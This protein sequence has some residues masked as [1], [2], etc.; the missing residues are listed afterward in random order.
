M[1]LLNLDRINEYAPYKLE[2]EGDIY[3]FETDYNIQYAVWFEQD[4]VTTD[5]PAYWF[6]LTNRSQKAPQE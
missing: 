2:L 3:L 6:N 4:P 1:E 5:T